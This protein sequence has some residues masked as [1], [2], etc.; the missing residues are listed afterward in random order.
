MINAKN[1]NWQEITDFYDKRIE[2]FVQLNESQLRHYFEPK[3]GIFLAESPL[4]IERA[5]EKGYEPLAFLVEDKMLNL[6]E[7]EKV[8]RQHDRTPVYYGNYELL[9]EMTGYGLT[10]GMVC[11]MH[12]KKLPTVQEIC[13]DAKRVAVMED[14][15]NPTNVGAIFRSA[16]ALHMDAVILT[17]ACSDP[18]YRRALRVSMG[19]VLLIPWT[20]SDNWQE[21]LHSQGFK[22]TAMA[23]TN[24]SVDINDER[25]QRE[26]KLAIVLGTEG[27]GLK[28]DTIMSCD[29][30]VKIPM[31][32]G[33][34]S[35]N[36]AAASAIA[37]WELGNRK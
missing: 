11:A 5:L 27:T 13:K 20:V 22:T 2:W 14:V 8:L 29:Y 21:E 19:N 36:V 24:E 9:K 3:E 15:V 17:S 7:T 33:V 31:S 32:N 25:L 6:P 23:L 34:D 28:M 10:R 12:R 26:D 30:T 35:L 1:E 18:L 37:F 16:A 4:V